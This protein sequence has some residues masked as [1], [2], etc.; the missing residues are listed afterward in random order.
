MCV[1][2]IHKTE[3]YS[4]CVFK[5]STNLCSLQL[6]LCMEN[7]WVYLLWPSR[8]LVC[9]YKYV[10]I[11]MYTYMYTYTYV[12]ISLYVY[13]YIHIYIYTNVYIDASC[14]YIYVYMH[15]HKY[16]Y[17]YGGQG[18]WSTKERAREKL[19]INWFY[20]RN[21]HQHIDFAYP[22]KTNNLILHTKNNLFMC[23]AWR[24]RWLVDML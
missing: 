16:V 15:A 3:K 21:R 14:V 10:N 2:S 13:V 19:L 4:F 23:S 7:P 20:M 17:I 22:K 9:V 5:S 12:Y 11:C 8:W 24:A 6:E 18:G 1:T